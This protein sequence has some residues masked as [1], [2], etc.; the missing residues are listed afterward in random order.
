MTGVVPSR[1]D[2]RFSALEGAVFRA[3]RPIVALSVL[4]AGTTIA[5]DAAEPAPSTRRMVQRLEQIARTDGRNRNPTVGCEKRVAIVR[6][7]RDRAPDL[8]Q[9]LNGSLRL[10]NELLKCG[11][12]Q[13]A[14][15]EFQQVRKLLPPSQRDA[16]SARILSEFLAMGYL[17]LGEQENCLAQHGPESC[18]LPLQGTGVHRAQR[19]ARAAIAELNAL[20]GADPNRPA[21]AWLLNLSYMAVGEYPDSVP[22]RSLIPP[23]IFASDYDVARFPNVAESAGANILGL[24]GGVCI[25]DFDGDG[26]LDLMVSAWGAREQLRFLHNQGD[27][28]FEDRTQQAGITGLTGGLNMNHAD[29]DNDG[30]KDVLVL[31]GAWLRNDGRHPNSL[32][33]NDGNGWFED[34]TEEAGLLSLHPT[35]T[36]QWGDFDNDGHLDLF[37]GN[38]STP[39]Q[40]SPCELYRNNGDGTFTNVAAEAGVAHV[41]FVKGV[42][43]GDFDNDG[44]L[45]LYL[46]RITQA[47]VLYRNTGVED[48]VPK[49]VDVSAT[50]RVTE[51]RNSFPTWF[52]DYD[53]DGWLDLFVAPFPGFEANTLDQIAADYVGL[54]TNAERPRLYRNLGDGTFADVTQMAGM[55]DAMLAM[56]ANFGDLD[57]DGYLDAYIGTGE[58]NLR[59]LVPNRMY[60]NDGGQGFQNVTTSGGFGHLQK[61]HGIG[62]G[63]LD[64]DGDQD[65]YAVMGGAYESD[66]AYNALFRN[67]GH[68]NRWVTLRFHG[69]K[70][71]RAGVGARV[72]ITVDT[73]RGPRRIHAIVNTGG[74][75]G[76]SSLQ[77]EIGLGRATAIREIEVRWPAGGVQRFR[78][79]TADRVYLVRE[80]SEA[81]TPA[82][83]T[84]VPL[85]R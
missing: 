11:L 12:T 2:A 47:N 40:R 77:Q 28:T 1:H 45:D 59:S 21:A 16:Q 6:E 63:D 58:P 31:R 67:P 4:L 30:D 13:E 60:R 57:N 48:G 64:N 66:L 25:D 43:C 65:V 24:S 3:R 17:R 10:G 76:S 80:D 61:G 71:N 82:S 14:I 51:P 23:R 7:L 55:N 37:I 34:V 27:G 39:E 26:R 84:V 81:L 83:V 19:G 20:L 68:G 54:P 8:R 62:F 50:A 29:Y 74:S 53:N 36:A 32:L 18:L 49:F 46:S 5:A 56:G 41:G 69:T 52:W 33:R 44:R 15:A 72:K 35:Q 22:Q 9:K 75:F 38:E 78:D 70:S 85:G 73:E 42:A 79:V